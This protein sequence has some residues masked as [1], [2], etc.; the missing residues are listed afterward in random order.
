[1]LTFNTYFSYGFLGILLPLTIIFYLILPQKYRRIVLLAA[2]YVFFWAISGKLLVYL[3]VSTILIHY[4]GLWIADVHREADDRMKEL[5]KEEKKTYKKE[6]SRRL[7]L[8]LAFGILFQLGILIVLKYAGFVTLNIN[9]FIRLL[10]KFEPL[11]IPVFAVPIGISFY[12][13]QAISYLF[14]VY[15]KS[16]KADRNLL[17]LALYMSFFPQIM[18][19]PICR[20]SQTAD[21]LWQAKPLE[22]HN[23]LSGFQRVLYGVMK[24][25]VVADRLN[26][27]VKNVFNDYGSYDGFI[28]AL[29]AVFYTI[30][31][32]MEFSGTMDLVIGCGEIFGIRM[33]ENFMRPFASVTI[34][35]FWKRW[36][37][38]LGGWFKDYIFYPLSASKPMKK[39]TSRS[40]KKLGNHFGPLV[41]GTIALFCV[42]FCNGLWHGAG[43]RYIFFGMYHFVL[44]LTGSMIAPYVKKTMKK[45]NIS[46]RSR[47]YRYLQMIRTMVLVC[48][49]ELFFRANGL[50]DGLFM[51]RKILSD[52]SLKTISKGTFFSMGF[53]QADLMIVFFVVGI[54]SFV[55]YF[56]ERKVSLRE[57]IAEKS[58]WKQWIFYYAAIM[59]VIIF[60]A[61]GASYVPV[62]PMYAAF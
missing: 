45:L 44:I 59:F 4:L 29:A 12:T 32:Y 19:G 17:R 16:I 53:D 5:G 50:K 15:R 35:E 31:L 11:A 40:R 21:Q 8:I 14:D 61:Y 56:Q 57:K 55:G 46:R 25:L 23:F 36:H 62:D 60:G 49:G 58:M 30:Q 43:W 3:L 34:S 39:L 38:S 20:Y 26:L 22:F 52:F 2:S 13:M 42:W 47:P 33:P 7:R 18:E 24:K 9:H 6:V 10:G 51:F 41:A 54:V 28:I 27:F 37:I 48:I 1:M